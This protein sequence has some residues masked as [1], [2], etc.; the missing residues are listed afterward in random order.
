MSMSMSEG[1][2]RRS[3]LSL[4]DVAA[5]RQWMGVLVVPPLGGIERDVVDRWTMLSTRHEPRMR[6]RNADA[7]FMM[8]ITYRVPSA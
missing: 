2:R 4:E 1:A 5:L 7:S 3:R 8:A 6:V